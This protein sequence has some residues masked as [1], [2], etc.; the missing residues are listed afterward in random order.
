MSAKLRGAEPEPLEPSEAP[1]SETQRTRC[2][3][4]EASLRVW[5]MVWFGEI[6]HF[7][8]SCLRPYLTL[9]EG[10]GDAPSPSHSA[11]PLPSGPCRD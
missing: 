3:N 5:V 8:A 6:Q 9:G 4:L 2:N 10:G 11:N 1:S 7:R